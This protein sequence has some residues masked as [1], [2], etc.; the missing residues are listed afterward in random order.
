MNRYSDVQLNRCFAQRLRSACAALCFTAAQRL[1]C[2]LLIKNFSLQVPYP[3]TVC[4]DLVVLRSAFKPF[5]RKMGFPKKTVA[6]VARNVSDL[7]ATRCA[8]NQ[9]AAQAQ[10]NRCAVARN[11]LSGRA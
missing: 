5:F 11:G 4:V 1:R 2:A 8:E 3:S 7:Y 9:S 6:P 10:R